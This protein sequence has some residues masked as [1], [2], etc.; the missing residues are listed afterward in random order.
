MATLMPTD[1]NFAIKAQGYYKL[2]L[3]KP[4]QYIFLYNWNWKIAMQMKVID[5]PMAEDG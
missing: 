2:K 5:V 1:M 4:D 3:H